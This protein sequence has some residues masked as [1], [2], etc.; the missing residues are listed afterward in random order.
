MT[1]KLAIVDDDAAFTDYLKVMLRTH[2]YDAQ[3]FHSGKELL[4]ALQAGASPSV[5][6]LDVSMP[7]MD[8][9]DTLRAV[10]SSQP[11]AQVIMLSGRQAP[12]TIVEA[13]RLGAADYVLKPGDPNGLGEAALNSAIRNAFERESLASE[14]A[15]L[16]AGF[17]EDPDGTQ[18]Y[19]GNG[20]EMQSVMTMVAR[21]ADSDVD[22][23]IRGESGVGKD[24]IA[25]E[26]HRRSGRRTKPFVKVNC[27]ALPADLLESEL[28]G[29][30]RGAFTGAAAARVG[31]FEFAQQGTVMLDEIGEMSAALQAKLLHVLQDRQFTRLGSNRV[32]DVDVRVIAATNRD[33]EEMLHQRTFREDLYYRLQ[34]IELLVPPLR[35]RRMEIPA[36][37]EFFLAKYGR[38]YRRTPIRPSSLFME[39]LV[40]YAWPG[41]IR[42]LENTIKRLVV[43][44][45]ESFILTELARVEAAGATR[46]TLHGDSV[47]VAAPVVSASS[48]ASAA[49]VA[50]PATTAAAPVTAV[51]AR[52]PEAP[53]D[54]TGVDLQ[55]L[56]KTA[57]MR[58]EREAIEA[59]LARFRWNRRK[60][61]EYLK[62]SYK[63]L[64]NKMRE[65]GIKES[66]FGD[67]PS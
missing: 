55:A 9:I 39:R 10:R 28:F 5:I 58:A 66:G 11:S 18:P 7:G 49:A 16:S 61:A 15:R 51:P 42:E 26:L 67:S 59:A 3:V 45:D 21:V 35:R 38:L 52:P 57:A 4:E 62:V 20:S 30:E 64:L 44:Q 22:V 14:V 53:D 1:G 40:N 63:T 47:N 12:A 25:R 27:A 31:K 8:G 60:A 36:L 24:V 6:L 48:A 43:L 29:H 13:V 2:G 23:L 65:S 34:V 33:L 19:W 32:V 56:A 37:A 46:A 50:A 54:A 17:A 41:N